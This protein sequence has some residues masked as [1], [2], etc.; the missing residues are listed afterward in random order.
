[1]VYRDMTFCDSDCSETRCNRNRFWVYQDRFAVDFLQK[2]P[3]TPI[4]FADFTSDC[5][6]YREVEYDEV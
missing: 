2:N 6:L 1:M 5:D 3:W 4:S